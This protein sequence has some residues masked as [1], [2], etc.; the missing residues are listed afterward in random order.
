[1]EAAVVVYLL[2]WYVGNYYFNI[3]NKAA[4][5]ASGGAAFAFT[6]ASLQLVIGSGWVVSLWVLG[7]RQR[8]AL[9][10]EV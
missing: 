8:P 1:M 9:S 4:G 5:I 2:L 10:R 6:L 7:L 3:F